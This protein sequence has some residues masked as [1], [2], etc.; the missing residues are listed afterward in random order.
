M[1]STPHRWLHEPEI[2]QC[3]ISQI[4]LRGLQRSFS[5]IGPCFTNRRNEA[6]M[7]VLWYQ[8]TRSAKS[9]LGVTNSSMGAQ[10]SLPGD[11]LSQERIRQRQSLFRAKL[12][13]IVLGS[14]S[15]SDQRVRTRVTPLLAR[16]EKQTA[17]K[18]SPC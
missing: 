1:G 12:K 9:K 5:P 8:L 10:R 17:D 6:T 3:V 7:V 15:D 4:P 18:P 16:E 11:L 2:N 13:N 14:S